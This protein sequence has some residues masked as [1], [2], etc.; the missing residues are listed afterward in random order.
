MSYN[1]EKA[2]TASNKIF[3]K[4]LTICEEHKNIELA[5][6]H[7]AIA[8]FSDSDS[9]AVRV[10]NK[11]QVQ[12]RTALDALEHT[13]SRL[14]SQT[15][16]PSNPSPNH[17]MRNV[18]QVANQL[19]QKSKSPNMTSDHLLLAVY[20]DDAVSRALQQ[21]GLPKKKVEETV[22][23]LKGNAGPSDSKNVEDNYGALEKYGRDLVVDAE[24]GKMD[25]IIG[26]DAEIRR[27]I[28]V[29]SR[30]TKNNP[31]LI[32]EPGVGKTAIIEGL[33][34]RIVRGD[35]PSSLKNRHLISLDVGALVAGASHRGEFEE[36]LKAVLQEVKDAEGG[37]IL[38]I[39]ELH[40]LIGAGGTGGAMD[41]SNLL[42]PGLARG[43]LRCIGAT[44]LD[45]YRK[46]IEKDAAFERRFQQVLVKE[47]TVND[48]ISILRGIKDRYESHFGVTIK[49]SALVVAAQLANRYITQR[50]LPDKAIDLIDEACAST[51]VQLDSRPSIIDELE[52]RKLQLEVEETALAKE[53]ETQGETGLND[54]LTT[55]RDEIADINAKLEPLLLQH[56]K[57]QGRVKTLMALK[58][59][60][61]DY[62]SKADKAEREKDMS[63]AADLRYGAIPELQSQIRKVEKE[64]QDEKNQIRVGGASGASG[65]AEMAAPRLLSEVV[66][67]EDIA[68]I[69]ARWTGIP[70]TRLS[71]TD[72]ERL[73]KLDEH[74]HRR[75]VGQDDAV[76]AVANAVLRSRAG[77]GR[78]NQPIGSF[79]FLGPT[80]VGK[81][82][83]SKALAHEL[84]DDEKH[85]VRMD[86]SEYGQE[87][88]VSRLIGAPPG[89]VGYDQGGALTEAVRRNPYSVV[90]FDEVEKA[91]P[92]V[93]NILLQVFDDGRLTDGQG[94][95]VDFTNTLIIMTSNIGAQ[96]LLENITP[97]GKFRDEET[98]KAKVMERVKKVFSPELL[99]RIDEVVVFS[100][101]TADILSNIVQQQL[102][103][104]CERLAERNILVRMEHGAMKLVMT[105]A[106]DPTF[107]ARPIKRWL[108]RNIV[109]ELSKLILS[110]R[111]SNNS[112]VTIDSKAHAAKMSHQQVAQGVGISSREYGAD[113]LDFRIQPITP[114]ASAAKRAL[115][116]G[117][118]A[119]SGGI[120]KKFML[121]Q[122]DSDDDEFHDDGDELMGDY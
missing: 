32:G 71:Q 82:E 111:L 9:F 36:R 39:D 3:M 35:V 112:L 65:N 14:P 52:R 46:Y 119:G 97:E 8:L 31:V 92:S 103:G 45:E 54:R 56:E 84:F 98:A 93:W 6:V 53:V 16:P 80:G 10:A 116:A 107:G 15:P 60:L 75:V 28:Q 30:R 24:N 43:E 20:E 102:H 17:S 77:L 66:G 109:T 88:N 50:F 108:E 85:M 118:Q 1:P 120:Q 27:V 100:P 83:L 117:A 25:P 63:R 74:L 86:M 11:L 2:T 12:A 73:L 76:T 22:R 58:S 41:A 113:K 122:P 69:V 49:D 26:R 104:V 114:K 51:R 59:K 67:P 57:E 110:G 89:Y 121:S 47:P 96:Y 23:A 34:Q 18:L 33:A 94:R 99:N 13:A 4:A 5:P 70:V 44:T 38:F 61:E 48:T 21:S 106:Y 101:L 115:E 29:L 37:I 19:Q 72:R 7:L 55:V 81:T 62:F 68:K 90:L 79:L 40:L 42:K 78:K 87:H 64:V 91:H 95:V 105:E